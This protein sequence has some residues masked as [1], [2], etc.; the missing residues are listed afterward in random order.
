MK[1]F[2]ITALLAVTVAVAGAQNVE[3]SKTAVDFGT[4]P[5]KPK[6]ERIVKLYNRTASP[7]VITDVNVDCNCT[8][9]EWSKK[10]IM[11]KDSTQLRIIYDP[12]EKGVFYK[13]IKV[14]TSAGDLALTIRGK[15]E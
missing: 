10:P 11:A 8:K 13:K 6:S 5:L 12:S 9:I 3:L 15:T 14:L 1:Q 7:I 2:F 4:I